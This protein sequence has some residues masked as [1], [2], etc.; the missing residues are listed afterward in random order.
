[1]LRKKIPKNP[2]SKSCTLPLRKRAYIDKVYSGNKKSVCWRKE[3]V[4]IR[5]YK[6]EKS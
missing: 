6:Y 1:M 5:K 3:P 4:K 2:K